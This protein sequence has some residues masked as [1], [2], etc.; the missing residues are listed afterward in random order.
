MMQ[1]LSQSRVSYRTDLLKFTEISDIDKRSKMKNSKVTLIF[2]F[3]KNLKMFLEVLGFTVQFG[4]LSE[5]VPYSCSFL[6]SKF[7]GP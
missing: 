2:N 4:L 7:L 5:N 6:F 1:S 3:F